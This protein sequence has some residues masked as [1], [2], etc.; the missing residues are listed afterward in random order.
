[1]FDISRS[2]RYQIRA[3]V[4]L[5]TSH[6]IQSTRDN[7]ADLYDFHRFESTGARLEFI[8][9][10]L[11]DNKYLFLVAEGVEGCVHGPNPTQREL[12]AANEWPMSTLH[13]A[14]I[15]PT[16]YLPHILSFGD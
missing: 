1:M 9:S 12:K 4:H 3:Q 15:N 11:P 2:N 13:P 10:H 16:G 5:I 6:C 7:I 14:G 8:D